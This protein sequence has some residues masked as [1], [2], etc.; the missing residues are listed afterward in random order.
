MLASLCIFTLV[1]PSRDMFELS[2]QH[3]ATI[4]KK[5]SGFYR[6]VS[7]VKHTTIVKPDSKR[8]LDS[9]PRNQFLKKPGYMM[10]Y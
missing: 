2:A 9:F 1:A 7:K 6:S 10:R 8:S 4:A 3:H 5:N